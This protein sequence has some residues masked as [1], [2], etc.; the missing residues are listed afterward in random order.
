[1]PYCSEFYILGLKSH[2]GY[3]GHQASVVFHNTDVS[4]AYSHMCISKLLKKLNV[5]DLYRV[6]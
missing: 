3:K 4:Y 1:M 5:C 2:I 6:N